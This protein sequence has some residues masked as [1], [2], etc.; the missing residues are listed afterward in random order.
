V[1]QKTNSDASGQQ[2]VSVKKRKTSS[3]KANVQDRE[4]PEL[5]SLIRLLIDNVPDLIWA[6]DMEDRFLFVN[7]AMCDK[8]LMCETPDE[9]V[10]KTD[11]Y[12]AKREIKNG[13]EHTFGEICINSDEIV[14]ETKKPGQFLEDG[15]V[16]GDYLSLDV[17]KAPLFDSTGKMIGTVGCGRDITT[18]RKTL[19]A[20]MESEERFLVFMNNFPGHVYI[21]DDEGRVLFI[22][23]YMSDHLGADLTW[24]NKTAVE[25]FGDTDLARTMTEDDKKA[26]DRG[27]YLRDEKVPLK[28]GSIRYYETR[29]FKLGGKDEPDLMGGISLDI[30]DRKAAEQKTIEALQHA[31]EHEKN[32]LIGRVAGKLAHD[33]NNIL[34]AVMGLAELGLIYSKNEKTVHSL[35]SILEQAIRGRNLTRNLVAFAKDS[36]PKQTFF[37]INDM[38]DSVVSL[39]KEDLENVELVRSY[40]SG[41]P[42]LLAD[43]NMIE[44]TLLN[45]IQNAIHA[46]SRTRE[47][48]LTLKTYALKEEIYVEIEDNGCG[49]PQKFEKDIFIPSFTLKGS[50]DQSG[51][52]EHGIKGTGYGMANVKKYID[53]HNGTIT[54]FTRENKGSKFVICLPII[55]EKLSA[56]E[57]KE[58]KAGKIIKEKT[59]LLV[60]DEQAISDIQYRVLTGEPFNHKVDVANNGEMAMDFF[61][62]GTYDIV[63]L[64]YILPYPSNGMDVYKHIRKADKKI[65]IL[66]VSGNIEFLESIHEIKRNDP[67]LDHLSKPCSNVEYT[68]SLNKL[69][70]KEK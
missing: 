55:Q 48:K 7:Q 61:D 34:G 5:S 15:M 21:K 58:L 8:L 47:P 3:S 20:F 24:L 13:H 19:N 23:K 54:F 64:D 52:Y 62:R 33:F 49:I 22:N 43:P 17:H 9:P 39:L 18:Q 46:M 68:D 10:G 16:R 25:I 29:K 32:A 11:L 35:Q 60:E 65:P 42:Q 12:F 36:E 26:M 59:L 4:F 70:Q 2:S 37:S 69:L 53:K 41:V 38:L 44:N 28:D 67:F 66:F 6:K 56:T 30:T 14:K 1:A 27:F 40:K 50:R 31:A 63:S 57:V 51:A 45:L